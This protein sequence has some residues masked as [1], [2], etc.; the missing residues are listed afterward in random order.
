[1][2]THPP[3]EEGEG[4]EG[5]EGERGEVEEGGG[6]EVRHRVLLERLMGTVRQVCN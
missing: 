5:V 1:M 6:V 3:C 4:R 2:H